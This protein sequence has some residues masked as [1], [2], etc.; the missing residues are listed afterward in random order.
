MK[1]SFI[2][3]ANLLLYLV[4]AVKPIAAQT[5]SEWAS[6]PAVGSDAQAVEQVIAG[7]FQSFNA[8]DLDKVDACY[9]GQAAVIMTDGSSSFEKGDAFEVLKQTMKMLDELPKY[10]YWNLQVRMLGADTALAVYDSEGSFK[11]Q[12]ATTVARV[13]ATDVLRRVNGKW[14]IELEQMTPVA[15]PPAAGN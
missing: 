9:S 14:L 7:L 11:Y 2:A 4:G 8:G 13:K 1:I 5:P 10:K 15:A 6:A 12:G 3:F